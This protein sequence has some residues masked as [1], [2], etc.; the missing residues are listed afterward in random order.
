MPL[1]SVM[2]RCFW[3][4]ETSSQLRTKLPSKT[5]L[6]ASRSWPYIKG[7][8]ATNTVQD[9]QTY[10]HVK[11]KIVG[12]VES[13][14]IATS[15]LRCEF[16]SVDTFQFPDHRPFVGISVWLGDLDGFAAIDESNNCC[17]SKM[18]S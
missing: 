10:P 1:T 9:K 7:Q 6:A 13:L 2:T 16:A 3:S 8:L 18:V 11:I 14:A 4:I 15:H 12:L 5:A 17:V